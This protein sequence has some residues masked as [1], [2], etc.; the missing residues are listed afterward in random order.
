[1]R[2]HESWFKLE[3]LS[4]FQLK[5]ICITKKNNGDCITFMNIIQVFQSN[6]TYYICKTGVIS[7]DLKQC[8][9]MPDLI[10]TLLLAMLILYLP[11][12]EIVVTDGTHSCLLYSY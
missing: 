1:M 3:N 5:F 11:H 6:S 7:S 2:H 4:G 9:D 12:P 8:Y 10:Y